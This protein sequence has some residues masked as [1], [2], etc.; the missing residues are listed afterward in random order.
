MREFSRRQGLGI[1]AAVALLGGC[2]GGPQL[3]SNLIQPNAPQTRANLALIDR[4]AGTHAALGRSWMTP[5]LARK[6]LL[7]VSNFYGSDILVFTY[8]GGK[9]VGTLTGVP[10]P[11]GECA[12]T[13]SGD[14]WV[15]AEDEMLEYGHGGTTPIATLSGVSGSCAIDQK[16]GDLAIITSDGI[17]VYPS[18]SG[19]GTSYCAGMSSGYFD[20][21]DDRGDLFIDAVTQ[22]D[23]YGLV[24]LPKGSSTCENITLSQRLEFPGG[25]QWYDKYLAVGDQEAHV[26][27][28]FAIHG[29]NAKEIDTTEL[30]G[31]SD[32]VQF[33]IQKPY[34]VAADAGNENAEMWKYPAGGP[35][36][37][38]LQGEFDL[39]IGVTVSIAKKR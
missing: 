31:S 11:Q 8:P 22:G 15:A 7:Y 18:G 14:W 27:Y 4:G 5:N 1:Y 9:L 20:A 29:R 6:D 32:V 12:S 26:I 38:T 36:F 17:I 10:D 16:T 23:T 21:Y 35:V 19:S 37:K 2:G 28:H 3:G 25:L 30:D 34:V 33:Y 24:E 13:S 39:P